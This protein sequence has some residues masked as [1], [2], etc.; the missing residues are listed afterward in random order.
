MFWKACT[1]RRGDMNLYSNENAPSIGW[2]TKHYAINK[3]F[4]V[5]EIPPG[6]LT[7]E[8]Y[9]TPLEAQDA[10]LAYLVTKRMEKS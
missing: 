1:Q 6:V 10:L 2:V 9:E 3:E 5:G 7:T 4:W 8:K